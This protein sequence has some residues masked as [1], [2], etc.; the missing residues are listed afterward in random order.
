MTYTSF[1][2]YVSLIN[3]RLNIYIR[4]LYIYIYIKYLLI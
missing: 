1:E 3:V 4:R 2:V